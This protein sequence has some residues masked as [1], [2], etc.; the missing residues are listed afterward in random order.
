MKILSD[1]E[2]IIL[3]YWLGDEFLLENLATYGYEYTIQVPASRD[4]TGQITEI[5]EPILAV[6]LPLDRTNFVTSPKS[7]LVTSQIKTILTDV[8]TMPPSLVHSKLDT[9]ISITF[10][11]YGSGPQRKM[12]L[13]EL[14]SLVSLLEPLHT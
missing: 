14:V 12:L 8:L 9:P 3:S 1:Q 6:K 2:L 5:E 7:I 11:L 4:F 10:V 13:L